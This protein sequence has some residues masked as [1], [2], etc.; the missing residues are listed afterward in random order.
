M[1]ILLR[2]IATFFGSGFCPI[3]PG[4]AASFLPPFV[5]VFV[6]G[7]PGPPRP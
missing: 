4:T 6:G 7:F 2:V 3:A 1:K 5:Y